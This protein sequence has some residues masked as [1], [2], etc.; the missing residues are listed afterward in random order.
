MLFDNISLNY[1]DHKPDNSWLIA[2][3]VI[4]VLLAAAAVLYFLVFRKKLA[5]AASKKDKPQDNVTVEIDNKIILPAEET[6]A[7]SKPKV[8]TPAKTI[9]QS[10]AK[11]NNV[12]KK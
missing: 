4:V 10:K 8:K 5:Y 1:I 12:K 3:I 11:E 7:Q 2:V 6:K 9:H